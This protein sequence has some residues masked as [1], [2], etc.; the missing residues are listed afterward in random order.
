MK[1]FVQ[2]LAVLCGHQREAARTSTI[3]MPGTVSRFFNVIELSHFPLIV[4]IFR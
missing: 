3:K 4:C 2:A 1:R